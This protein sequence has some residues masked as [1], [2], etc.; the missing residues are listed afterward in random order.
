LHF[1][2]FLNLST[3]L[4]SSSPTVKYKDA[5]NSPKGF[6]AAL[7][8]AEF[9]QNSIGR[10]AALLQSTLATVIAVSQGPRTMDLSA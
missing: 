9:W 4:S 3:L 5:E 6:A 2:S 1:V 10:E 7:R 8:R